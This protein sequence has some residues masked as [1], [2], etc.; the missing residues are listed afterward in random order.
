MRNLTRAGSWC[1][2]V[3][4]LSCP[5]AGA[6]EEPNPAAEPRLDGLLPRWEVGDRWTLETVSRPLSVRADV[7]QAANSPPLRWQFDVSRLEESLSDEC[8]RVEV[9]CLAEG[10]GIPKTVF[11]LHRDSFALCRITSYMPVPG[12]FE[13]MTISYDSASGQPAPILGPLSALPI[14]TPVLY[15]GAK[16]LQTFSYASHFGATQGKELGDV[17]FVHQVQQQISEMPQAEVGRL[18]GE[19]FSKSLVEDAFAKSLS[20]L[21]VT[22]IRL[23]SQ[24]REIRQLWQAHRPWPIYCDNGY[25]VSRLVSVERSPQAARE[26]DRP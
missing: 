20:A 11:W 23:K 22:E 7:S 25:S 17:G 26:E 19:H 18:L 24:G 12:G 1:V 3:T 9:T 16:G 14:D 8:F 2:A 6:A 15:S 13:A 10:V 21:P 4:L 5:F